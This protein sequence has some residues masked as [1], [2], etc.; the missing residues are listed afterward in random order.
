MNRSMAVA[1][2]VVGAAL[3]IVSGL[4][5]VLG[6]GGDEGVFGWKQILGLVVGVALL[7][8]GLGRL[9]PGRRPAADD[10]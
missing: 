2:V 8:V 9:L 5:D 1:M 6:I 4:G 3:A 7:A 10:G